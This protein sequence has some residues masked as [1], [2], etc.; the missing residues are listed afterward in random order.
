M[1]KVGLFLIGLAENGEFLP[2]DGKMLD[3]ISTA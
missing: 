3:N 1:A 2:I